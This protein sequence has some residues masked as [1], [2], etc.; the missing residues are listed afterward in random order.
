M[1]LTSLVAAAVIGSIAFVAA[2]W[3]NA[4]AAPTVRRLTLHV[5]HWQHSVSIAFFS[6]VHVHGPDMP[7]SRVAGIVKTINSLHPDIVISAGDFIGGGDLGGERYSATDAIAPFAQLSPKLG[8]YAVLGNH[9]YSDGAAAVVRA[10]QRVGAH[11]LVNDAEAVGPIALA[12]IDGRINLSRAQWAARREGVYRA[13]ARTPG[14]HII[15]AHRPDEFRW[16]PQSA[17]LTLAGHTHCGQIVL[18]LVG[19]IATGSDFGTE[20]LCGVIRDRSK[21]LVVTAGLGTSHLPLRIGAPPDLWFITI[22]GS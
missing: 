4:I 14:I 16:A 22:R 7:P 13:L 19:P 6:D 3:R 17:L 11:V 12:G 8:F 9:D 10:L 2:G 18:P 21:T 20:Y 1:V 15:V 5:P